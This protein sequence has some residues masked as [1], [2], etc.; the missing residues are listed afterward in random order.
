MNKKILYTA[1]DIFWGT[2]RIF[3]IN[4]KFLDADE[5][6]R[7]IKEMKDYNCGMINKK[8]LLEMIDK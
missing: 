2:D 1:E 5:V 6:K 7:I 8:E 4:K 3:N